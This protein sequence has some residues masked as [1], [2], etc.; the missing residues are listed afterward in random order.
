MNKFHALLSHCL[1]RLKPYNISS[2][3]VTFS[4]LD[5]AIWWL[6]VSGLDLVLLH[7]LPWPTTVCTWQPPITSNLICCRLE[8]PVHWLFHTISLIDGYMFLVHLLAMATTC[9]LFP[10]VSYPLWHPCF[11]YFLYF[12]FYWLLDSCGLFD[13]ISLA[14]LRQP[15]DLPPVSSVAVVLLALSS[16]NSRWLAYA[17]S[18]LLVWQLAQSCQRRP[19]FLLGTAGSVAS[20]SSVP[21]WP[22]QLVVALCCHP[23]LLHPT[24]GRLLCSPRLGGWVQLAC[25]PVSRQPTL[26]C[27]RSSG[28]TTLLAATNCFLVVIYC[29]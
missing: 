17:R 4:D 5:T 8:S 25:L 15:F 20:P 28:L 29:F 13:T 19:I 12:I 27:C 1:Q 26:L 9:V 22:V 2:C 6:P 11:F 18:L 21:T 24:Y 7:M 14:A 3:S 10:L 16:R 23:T